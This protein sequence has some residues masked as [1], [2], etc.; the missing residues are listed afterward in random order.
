MSRGR[1]LAPC[2]EGT[3]RTDSN[4]YVTETVTRAAPERSL[5]ARPR[6][7]PIGL[8]IG[9]ATAAVGL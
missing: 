6:W 8:A 5:S 9:G 3:V 4:G 7:L 1:P 2:A